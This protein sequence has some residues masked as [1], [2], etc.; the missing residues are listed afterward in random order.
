MEISSFTEL[1][2]AGA[3]GKMCTK[4]PCTTC[5][6]MVFRQA[7]K[8]FSKD[9]VV[10]GLRHSTEKFL[11][12]NN[13]MFRLI[14]SEI[15]FFPTGGDLL[16]DLEGSAAAKQL[17]ANIDYQNQRFEE[18][19]A[20]L[21]SQTPE[22]IA[23]CRMLRKAARL[24]STAKHRDKKLANVNAMHAALDKLKLTPDNQVLEM[25]INT[26]LGVS[27]EALGGLVFGRLRKFYK[28]NTIEKLQLE[29]LSILADDYSGHWAK[30]L[31]EIKLI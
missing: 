13:E 2:E 14:I 12:K 5:G 22:A 17:I 23:H 27:K 28:L 4:F 25:I 20:Y 1:L 26:D 30:L 16:A 31:R 3:S 18:R 10:A 8:A 19:Q 29:S 7:M 15:S 11:A 21:A 24:D 9:E 6:A